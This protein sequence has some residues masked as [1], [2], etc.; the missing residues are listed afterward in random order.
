VL[1]PAREDQ[2]LP[3]TSYLRGRGL[4]LKAPR[5]GGMPRP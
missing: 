5:P 4:A 2:L 1:D 3:L